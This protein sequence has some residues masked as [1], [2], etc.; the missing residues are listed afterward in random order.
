MPQWSPQGAE[1]EVS[2]FHRQGS[3]LG[4]WSYHR[5]EDLF[6]RLLMHSISKYWEHSTKQQ[7]VVCLGSAEAYSFYPLPSGLGRTEAIEVSPV[8]P[9]LARLAHFSPF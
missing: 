5:F 2:T 1:Q 7:V 6:T 4:L 9:F 3:L 8:S